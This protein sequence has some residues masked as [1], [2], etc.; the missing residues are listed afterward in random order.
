MSGTTCRGVNAA[1]SAMATIRLSLDNANLD[2][3]NN[4]KAWGLP[5]TVWGA[6]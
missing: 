5:Y 1:D 2:N 3:A 6:V 4:Q